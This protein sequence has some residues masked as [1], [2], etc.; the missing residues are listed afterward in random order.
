M[1]SREG[2]HDRAR[3]FVHTGYVPAGV[4]QHPSFGSIVAS[5]LMQKSEKLPAYV[6]INGPGMPAGLLGVNFAPFVIRDAE[7]P[8]E[9][10]AFSDSV[11]RERFENRLQLLQVLNRTFDGTHSQEDLRKKEMTY[12]RA[13]DLMNSPS[14]SAFDLTKES[15]TVR[16]RYGNTKIGNGCLMAKRLIQ[17]GVK[18]V[19]VEMDGWDTHQDNFKRTKQLLQELDPAFTSLIQD[20]RSTGLLESTLIVWMGEF[21]RTPQIN[22]NAGR[23]HWPQTWCAVLAG[24]GIQGGQILGS[25]DSKGYEI[26]NAP[27]SVPDLYA[28][29]CKCL[30]ID[31]SKYNSSPLGRP[32]RITDHGNAVSSLL[33]L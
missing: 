31:D 14:L 21:G 29:L 9:N 7:K 8:P 4:T 22:S 3:Y 6:S 30:G 23:D 12:E 1:N 33:R 13:I 16:K 2:N 32:I 27:V 25:S 26:T 18:F 19:E 28:T 5:E 10:L 20:L 11:T 24:G 17:N 15:E